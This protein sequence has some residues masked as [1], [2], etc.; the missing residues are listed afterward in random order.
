CFLS[1]HLQTRRTSTLPRRPPLQ[2]IDHLSLCK[3]KSCAVVALVL[4]GLFN[5]LFKDKAIAKFPF[6]PFALVRKLSHRGLQGNDP[7]DYSTAFLYLLY[8][9]SIRT[10]L[11]M[12]LKFYPPRGAATSGGL[13]LLPIPRSIDFRL[14]T[15]VLI[16]ALCYKLKY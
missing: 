16:F 15:K 7:T 8:F 9:V 3:F 14:Q 5:S 2:A 10:N 6:H 1:T 13:F 12:F 11:Q 4:F